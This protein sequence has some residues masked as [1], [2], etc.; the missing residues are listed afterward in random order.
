[1]PKDMGKTFCNRF[2]EIMPDERIGTALTNS[3]IQGYR[4][5]VSD[6]ESRGGKRES[7]FLPEPYPELRRDLGMNKICRKQIY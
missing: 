2:K 6:V 1:M 5:G 7:P 3:C 4:K